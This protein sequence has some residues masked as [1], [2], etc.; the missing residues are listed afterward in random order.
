MKK[1]KLNKHN[2]G[3]RREIRVV[4]EELA[5]Y[6]NTTV[7]IEATFIKESVSK[8]G[9]FKTVLL[10]QIFLQ[11]TKTFV[12]DHVWIKSNVN[13]FSNL[14]P[15]AKITFMAKV[16]TYIKIKNS[17]EIVNYRLVHPIC[18]KEMEEK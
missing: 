9:K 11:E 5:K 12:T 14:K 6:L 7:K 13:F 8:G 15:N 17:E 10:R 16:E 1:I 18:I 4:R 3:R 2:K